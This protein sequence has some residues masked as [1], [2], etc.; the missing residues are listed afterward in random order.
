VKIDGEYFD[1]AFFS[2]KED[3]DLSWRAR[4]LGW[5]CV[6]APMAVAYHR[7]TFRPHTGTRQHIDAETKM[8]AVKNRYLLL[9]KNEAPAGLLRD[10]LHIGLYDLKI[11]TYVLLFERSSLRALPRLRLTWARA[12]HWRREIHRRAKVAPAQQAA[13]FRG[14]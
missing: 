13:W 7:R 10:W 1:E 6:Y 3:V 14:L 12:M 5:R 8:H 4:I 11:L 9:L 2:H